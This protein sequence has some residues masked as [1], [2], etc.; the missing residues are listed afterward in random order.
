ML[1]ALEPTPYPDDLRSTME[2]PSD[3]LPEVK[4]AEFLINVPP[5]QERLIDVSGE[6][7]TGTKYTTGVSLVMPH[8]ALHCDTELCQGT[9]YY[10]YNAEQHPVVGT[11]NRSA[12]LHFVCR[13]CGISTK[14]YAVSMRFT[15][16]AHSQLSATKY[17]EIPSFGPPVPPRV[18][19]LIG[20][21]REL[22]LRGRRA[23]N[24]GL[25]VGAFA[26]YRQVV[27][28]Q[29]ER[30]LDEIGKVAV[31]LNAPP[32]VLEAFARARKE[33]Q[34]A[35]ALE[36]VKHAIPDA[37]K[38][39]GHN[40]LLLLYGPLSAGIHQGTDEECLELATSIRSVLYELADRIGQSLKDEQ[41]LSH[42]VA[43]LLGKRSQG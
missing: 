1:V 30:L 25:G 35:K 31:R 26:Y 20:P 36:D 4:L 23:E 21:D 3:G 2:F 24:M 42:A 38:I 10:R 37:L 17:G 8:I 14:R 6:G 13:N 16:D 11:E 18:L 43:K 5:G 15:D 40:P 9:R 19:S 34:F 22:F 33:T 39:K 41:E 7:E 27:E 32:E 12:F 28:R 29:K